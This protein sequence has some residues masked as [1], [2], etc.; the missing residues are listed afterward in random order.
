M[1]MNK[2]KTLLAAGIISLS[3]IANANNTKTEIENTTNQNLTEVLYNSNKENIDSKT[4]SREEAQ[5]ME[6]NEA[7]KEAIK[8]QVSLNIDNLEDLIKHY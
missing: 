7:T 3:P 4:I 8:N 6:K 1:I 2:A 5:K